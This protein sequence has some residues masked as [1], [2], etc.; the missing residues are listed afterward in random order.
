M[1]F[2]VICSSVT[3]LVA[4][5]PLLRAWILR[6]PISEAVN[7]GAS[8]ALKSVW[9]TIDRMLANCGMICAIGILMTLVLVYEDPFAGDISV[10]PTA[11]RRVLGLMDLP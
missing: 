4:L 9:A 2:A 11:L 8:D 3:V 7:Q 1:A 10:P 5:M 6:L